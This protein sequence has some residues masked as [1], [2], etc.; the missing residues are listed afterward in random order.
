[1]RR[2]ENWE[3]EGER[4]DQWEW[5]CK[6]YHNTVISHLCEVRMRCISVWQKDEKTQKVYSELTKSDAHTTDMVCVCLS[7][8]H[9]LS[10][11]NVT[12]PIFCRCF[13]FIR[14]SLPLYPPLPPSSFIRLSS[15]FSVRLSNSRPRVTASSNIVQRDLFRERRDSLPI[16]LPAPPSVR[17]CGAFAHLSKN[18]HVN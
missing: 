11:S 5:C 14:L 15:S 1:M 8:R 16:S 17:V 18:R 13:S 10:A 12:R 3:C 2:R 9:V 7:V 4:N 6:S